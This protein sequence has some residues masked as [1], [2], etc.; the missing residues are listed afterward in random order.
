MSSFFLQIVIMLIGSAAYDVY[1]WGG[2][3]L[4]T[5]SQPVLPLVFEEPKDTTGWA[6]IRKRPS[7]QQSQADSNYVKPNA[8]LRKPRGVQL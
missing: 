6:I 3:G 5:V 4:Q 1:E 2:G 7:T 8:S